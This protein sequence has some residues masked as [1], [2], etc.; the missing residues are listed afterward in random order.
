MIFFFHLSAK[1]SI[2]IVENFATNKMIKE[3]VTVKQFFG[4]SQSGNLQEAVR[5]LSNPQLILL[6]S[7]SDQ[8]E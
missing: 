2:I 7:N 4:V 1:Y 8:I 3:D 5:G 6:M